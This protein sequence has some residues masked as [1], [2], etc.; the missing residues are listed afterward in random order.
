MAPKSFPIGQDSKSNMHRS[1]PQENDLRNQRADGRVFVIVRA[2]NEARVI[3][4][5]VRLLC[6]HF[7]R[8]VVVDDGSTDSTTASLRGLKVTLISHCVNLGGGAALQTG[9]TYALSRDAEWILTFDADGQHRVEDALALLDLLRS[10]S[11]DVVFGS[12]FLGATINMPKGRALLLFA[13]RWF[14]NFTSGIHLTDTHNGLR[15]FNRKAASVINISQNGMAYASE[16]LEQLKKAHV[17][18]R[19]IPVTIVYTEYSRRKGQSSFN[20]INILIDLFVGRLMR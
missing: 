14:S 13:A 10:G 20:A 7:D 18:I 19:E 16:I 15:G 2:Y 1:D 12:R 5:V 17:R 11:C 4:D 9:I 6:E 3:R 8:V